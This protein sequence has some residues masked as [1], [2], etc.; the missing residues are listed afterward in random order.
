[1]AIS[2]FFIDFVLTL[3]HVPF[4][5]EIIHFLFGSIS[6]AAAVWIW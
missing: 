5:F 3:F 2:F 4:V 6:C 1:M